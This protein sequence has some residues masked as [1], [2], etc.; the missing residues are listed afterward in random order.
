MYRCEILYKTTMFTARSNYA[1]TF[2][3]IFPKLLDVTLK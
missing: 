3:D 2:L 1:T